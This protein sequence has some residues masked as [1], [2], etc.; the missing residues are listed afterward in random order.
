MG[1]PKI[2]DWRDYG[3]PFSEDVQ[4][5]PAALVEAVEAAHTTARSEWGDEGEGYDMN[6]MVAVLLDQGWT[7]PHDLAEQEQT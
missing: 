1:D 5:Q 2:L 6:I 7:P 3:D 4:P